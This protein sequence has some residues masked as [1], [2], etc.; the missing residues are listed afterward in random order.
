MRAVARDCFTVLL[1]GVPL[2]VISALYV[3]RPLAEWAATH[4]I[5]FAGRMLVTSIPGIAV[6]AALAVPILGLFAPPRLLG[7][8]H[9][10]ML[11]RLAVSVV[12]TAAAIELI[13]KRVFGRLP[14]PSWVL[15]HAFGFHWF[16]GNDAQL[17]SFPSGEAGFTMAVISILWF[18]YPRWRPLLALAACW[19]AFLLTDLQWHFLGDVL[20]GG[21][22]GIIGGLVA[23]HGLLLG[24]RDRPAIPLKRGPAQ[25]VPE[26]CEYS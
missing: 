1:V 17:R 4:E 25:R 5:Q 16:G 10:T 15:H 12:W 23:Q 19:E 13:L 20:G 3:D 18:N 21:M 26:L 11:T 8:Q 9:W 7:S 14:P 2:V 24:V 6:P 22:V